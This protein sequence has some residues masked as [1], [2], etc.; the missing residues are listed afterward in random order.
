[1]ILHVASY[2]LYF[3][4]MNNEAA[5]TL[6][7]NIKNRLAEPHKGEFEFLRKHFKGKFTHGFCPGMSTLKI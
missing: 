7:E 5:L 6:G 1:M 2:F 4:V 3:I